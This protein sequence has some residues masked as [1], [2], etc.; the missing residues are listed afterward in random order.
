MLS[1][2]FHWYYHVRGEKNYLKYIYKWERN[3][4]KENRWRNI[5]S[6]GKKKAREEEKR[7]KS[8]E[9]EKDTGERERT[10]LK[11]KL[12]TERK[13]RKEDEEEEAKERKRRKW[14]TQMNISQAIVLGISDEDVTALQAQGTPPEP[15]I[16]PGR[17]RGEVEAVVMVDKRVCK[18]WMGFLKYIY[19][20]R[21]HFSS[22]LV[23][24]RTKQFQIT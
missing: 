18:Q 14:G 24:W 20:V 21:N 8:S 23:P 17:G 22:K 1:K 15:K 7:K 10:G 19:I 13:R 16:T 12:E 4:E 6:E 2:K 9:E 3:I 5:E 11:R